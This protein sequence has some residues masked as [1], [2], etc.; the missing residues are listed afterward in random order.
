MVRKGEPYM[1]KFYRNLNGKVIPMDESSVNDPSLIEVIPNT[2]DAAVEKHVPVIEI[3]DNKVT[4]TVGSVLHPMLDVHYIEWIILETDRGFFK[5]E[6]KPG[7]EPKA[8]FTIED[9][10][11]IAA[12]ELCNLHG[13]WKKEL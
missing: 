7:Q 8:T 5:I 4:V 12:Y 11:V 10:K 6:L 3:N 9:E 2:T 13:L 1:L